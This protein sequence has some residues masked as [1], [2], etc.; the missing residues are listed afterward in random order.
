MNP[1]PRL[2]LL[3]APMVIAGC[4]CS[5][6]DVNSLRFKC[7]SQADCLED[8]VCERSVCIRADAGR[9]DAG[10]D[11][12]R[13][14]GA[15]AGFDGGEDAGD[16]AGSDADAGT[17]GGID[18]GADAGTDAGVDAGIDAGMPSGAACTN[19]LDCASG[20]CAD[21]VCCNSAC[22]GLCDRCNAAG[23]CVPAPPPDGGN[24]CGA[25][26]CIADAGSCQSSCA[27]PTTCA[28][29]AVCVSNQCLFPRPIGSACTVGAECA[30]NNCVD[31]Y[32]CG[33]ACAGPCDSCDRPG[34]LGVCSLSPST[35]SCG[36]YTCSGTS[37]SC[38]TSCSNDLGCTAPFS[39]SWFN[40]CLPRLA[41]IK[42][43]FNDNTLEAA[44]WGSYG[45]VRAQAFERNQR[46]EIVLGA[47]DSGY[48]GIYA[49]SG[50][51]GSLI[52]SSFSLELISA[53]LQ[54]PTSEVYFGVNSINGDKNSVW[55]NVYANMLYAYQTV[56]AGQTLLAGTPYSPA[57]VRYLRLREDGGTTYWEYSDGGAFQ[58]LH[59]RPNPVLLNG[60]EMTI[61]AGT[62]MAE[63]AGQ[64]VIFDNVNSP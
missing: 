11:A 7:S 30:N 27:S 58:V 15:D 8:Y 39:C 25:F 54:L 19:S 60:V 22:L 61:G 35:R 63:D 59:S 34:L 62:W 37:A 44:T 50:K 55:F 48:A 38:P 45:G 1:G 41:T 32:C 3:L 33:G 56:D 26:R 13:D 36:D 64:L 5:A 2:L 52:G 12:G 4:E 49:Q 42:D 20:F 43:D 28:S 10:L 9:L 40:R 29:G 21:G 57:K 46:L 24:P 51:Y 23:S 53:G 31:G 6:P 18:A 16:D 47:L 17:D 14:A